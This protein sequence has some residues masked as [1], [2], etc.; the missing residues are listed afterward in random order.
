MEAPAPGSLDGACQNS[1]KLRIELRKLIKAYGADVVKRV[2]RNIEAT[3]PVENRRS[4]GRP[5]G[6]AI[7]DLPSLSRAAVMWRERG[8]GPVWPALTAVGKSLPGESESNARR[9]LNRLLNEESGWHDR[10]KR[11]GIDDFWKAAWERK[12]I[13]LMH[14]ASR[15]YRDKVSAMLK[16]QNPAPSGDLVND[17][18]CFC[19]PLLTTEEIFIMFQEAHAAKLIPFNIIS[20]G[21]QYDLVFDSH[22][23]DTYLFL[24]RKFSSKNLLR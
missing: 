7:D 12:I 9:L 22:P 18:I 1:S 20:R 5:V 4:R 17:Y 24:L 19:V 8:G 10:F 21:G 6:P 11:A 16:V 2:L 14:R 15:G 23:L 3:N 13:R